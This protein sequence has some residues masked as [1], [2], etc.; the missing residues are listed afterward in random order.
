MQ[1]VG[2]EQIGTFIVTVST[3]FFG[4]FKF[5]L[6]KIQGEFTTLK[7]DLKEFEKTISKQTTDLDKTIAVIKSIVDFLIKELESLKRK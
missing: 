4:I 2:L 5:M 7:K 6:S 3:V 1:D